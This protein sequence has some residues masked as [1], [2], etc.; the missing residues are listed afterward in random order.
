M[1]VKIGVDLQNV[2]SKTPGSLIGPAFPG[3]AAEF[4]LLLS[5][6]IP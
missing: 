3:H 6:P 2:C 5:H 1:D 4:G